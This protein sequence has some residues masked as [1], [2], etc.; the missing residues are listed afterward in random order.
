MG[1]VSHDLRNPLHSIM[2]STNAL[3]AADESISPPQAQGLARI[4]NAARRAELLIHSLLDFARVRSGKLEIER[5]PL[6]FHALVRAVSD[7]HVSGRPDRSLDVQQSGLGEGEWDEARLSQIVANLV[8]NALQYSPPDS[9][10]R[11][12]SDGT[13]DEVLLTVHNDGKPIDARL[14]PKVFE[15][16]CHGADG[17]KDRTGLG[18]YIAQQAAIA[19]GGLISVE[20]SADAGTT[21]TLR[22]PRHKG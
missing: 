3:L 22:L 1:V 4:H 6:D 20:S 9:L 8:G 10:V 7:E 13:N 2:L 16:F 18:L 17:V 14:L 19:H 21:F 12:R 5:K 11:I 15:P